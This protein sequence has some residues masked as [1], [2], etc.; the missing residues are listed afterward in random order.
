M[1]T[2][3]T[4]N[5]KSEFFLKS[6]CDFDDFVVAILFQVKDG[7]LQQNVAV[8]LGKKAFGSDEATVEKIKHIHED[9]ANISNPDRCEAANLR[10]NCARE[11]AEKVGLSRKKN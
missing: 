6:K 8:E 11:A 7:V 5:G 9:C 1:R 10:F 4:W 2:G 3:I